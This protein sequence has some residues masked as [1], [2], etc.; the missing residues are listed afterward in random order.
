MRRISEL[1]Y[2]MA[3]IG[4]VTS[5]VA[6]EKSANAAGLLALMRGNWTATLQ[7]NTGCGASSIYATFKLDAAGHGVGTATVTMHSTG[8]ADSTV[9]GQDFNITSLN[10]NTG[11][12]KAGLSC[13]NGCGGWNFNIQVDATGKIMALTDVDPSNLN[14][15]P[16]GVALHT[17]Q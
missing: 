14:N 6:G 10:A 2:W 4:I 3:A 12:G 17:V 13:G 11:R 7:G 16:T 15:T 9:T 1:R 5:I 8:C